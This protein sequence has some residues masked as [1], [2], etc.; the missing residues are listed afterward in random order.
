MALAV[1]ALVLALRNQDLQESLRKTE[2]Q[3]AKQ[4]TDLSE[5]HRALETMSAPGALHAELSTPAN[6]E[7][8]AHVVY[9]PERGRLALVAS[10]LP[11]LKFGQVYQLWLIPADGTTP[12]PA[13]TF[14]A[15]ERGNASM[16]MAMPQ[17]LKVEGFQV[18]TEPKGG[19]MTPSTNSVLTGGIR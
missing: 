15:D 4:V 7:P 11:P 19:T 6:R 16:F 1:L 2:K 8:N 9:Q 14:T 5:A 12:L 17:N 3:S 10:N 13:G 18:T